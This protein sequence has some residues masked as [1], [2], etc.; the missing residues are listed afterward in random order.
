MSV[1]TYVYSFPEALFNDQGQLLHEAGSYTYTVKLPSGELSVE[2]VPSSPAEPTFSDVPA[3]SWFARGV[4]TCAREGI[5][6]GTGEDTFSP[7]ATLTYPECVMLAYRL[8]DKA[9]GGDGSLSKAPEDWSYM[10]IDTDDGRL[11][12][13]G[14]AGD[15]NV[16]GYT[17][18]TS[19]EG[20]YIYIKPKD[21]EMLNLFHNYYL[22]PPYVDNGATVTLEGTTYHGTVSMT[23]QIAYQTYYFTFHPDD[24]KVTDTLI[25]AQSIPA[26]DK[27]W[28]DLAYTVYQRGWEELF[29]LH[30]QSHT[31]IR[32]TFADQLAA[33]TDLPQRFA[34]PVIPDLSREDF[35]QV[36]R[37]YEAG[38]LG[39]T[40]DYGT[41]T[42]GGE[43]TRAEAAVMV[44]RVLDESQR[45]KEPPSPMPSPEGGDYTLTYLSGGVLSWYSADRQ[46]FCCLERKTGEYEREPVGFL[47]LEGEFIP[48]EEVIPQGM[49]WNSTERQGRYVRIWLRD[50]ETEALSTGILDENAR[51]VIPPG[52]YD[53]VWALEEG[54]GASIGWGEKIQFFLL[55]TE[56][57][58]IRQAEDNDPAIAAP[59]YPQPQPWGGVT[60]PNSWFPGQRYYLWP[61][62][63]PASGWFDD[64]G[65]LSPDGRGF[66][67]KDGKI[68][69]IQFTTQEEE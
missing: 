30:P 40:D 36:F 19:G 55:D 21:M 51:W 49:E 65:E 68:Y 23:R 16:W 31:A 48:W 1:L 12:H 3:D 14:F 42:G 44:A 18:L 33:V 45:L 47:T 56:G 67:E 20:T 41:F 50:Q 26:G 57:Q 5:M 34:V 63:S 9:R 35:P 6:M 22:G 13:Q 52:E 53:S 29:H 59:D 60:A 32:H 4:A 43:L 39:G 8:Y 28:R 25:A 24:P 69:R 46:P 10:T 37:L 15:S 17:S 64:C 7:E 27:W 2:H 61:D 58:I 66:V 62:G 54:F 11:H 38:V